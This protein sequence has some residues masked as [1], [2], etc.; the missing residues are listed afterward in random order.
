MKFFFSIFLISI[1]ISFAYIDPGT[2]G[3][4]LSS[5]WTS[6]IGFMAL[7]F[8][9]I[10]RFFRHTLMNFLKIVYREHKVK[11]FLI[12]LSVLFII[13]QLF[14][15]QAQKTDLIDFREGVLINNLESEDYFLYQEGLFLTN[16]SLIKNWSYSYL[17]FIDSE[18]FYYAQEYYESENWGKFHF[19]GTLIWIKPDKIHH[20]IYETQN[21]TIVTMTKDVHVYNGREV[22]FDVILEYN[23]NGTL[24][25]R[26]SLWDHLEEFQKWHN[27]LEL[28][29]PKNIILPENHRKENKSIWGG[30]YDYYHLN[31]F[32]EVPR[33]KREGLH[34][35]FTPGNW[36]LSFRHGSMIFILDQNTKE[37]LWRGIYD[38]IENNLEGQHAPQ[39]NSNG[40][41]IVFD[42]GR[43]RE[44]SRIIT[45][46]PITLSVIENY[47]ASDFFTG[48]QGYVQSLSNGNLFITESEEGRI[49]EINTSGNIIWE[50]QKPVLGGR[51]NTSKTELEIYRSYK[52]DK[53][54]IDSLMEE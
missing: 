33:N 40:D 3:Y 36:I 28:D 49:F 15:V 19:N 26:F 17:P 52:Y 16:G 23:K 10:L 32:S 12:I 7:L 50:Y 54:F 47:V 35:A 8:G 51:E 46:N 1:P 29:K 31:S 34:P 11:L 39:M 2:G 27:K 41:I 42:N 5:L 30:Y 9:I 45:I 4:L 38:Q 18:G 14:F 20:E 21:N 25:E 53:E 48:S 37:I 44:Y 22:E 43:Y 24:I 13:F 6:F